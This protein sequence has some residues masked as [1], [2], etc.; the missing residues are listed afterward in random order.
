M[1]TDNTPKPVPIDASR[2][3]IP[4]KGTPAYLREFSVAAKLKANGTPI[5]PMDL[6][7][8]VKFAK[9]VTHM[10]MTTMAPPKPVIGIKAASLVRHAMRTHWEGAH[11]CKHRSLGRNPDHEMIIYDGPTFHTEA[12]RRGE[13]CCRICLNEFNNA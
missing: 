9:A 4:E 8:V 1:K 11:G 7:E 5:L 13:L 3:W 6:E 10:Q 2:E 12:L